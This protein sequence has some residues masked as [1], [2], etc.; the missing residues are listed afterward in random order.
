MPATL[1]ASVQD[2]II[3]RLRSQ[4]MDKRKDLWGPR[5]LKLPPFREINHSIP[6]IDENYR[7]FSRPGKCPEQ[8]RQVYME[9]I[10]TYE[11]A[12][13]WQRASVPAAMPM[14]P[15][16][17]KDNRI[18]T[19]VD[20][21]QRNDNTVK[22]V[23]PFPDQD[24]IRR[25]V[26]RAKY[27]SKVDQ[28][29]FFEQIRVIPDVVGKTAF[30]TPFGTFVSLVA[31]QGDCNVPSTAQQLMNFLFRKILGQYVHAY[32]DDIFVFSDTLEEHEEHLGTVFQILRD[33]ELYLSKDKIDLY[34]KS[35][36]C[37]G[38]VID[39]NGLHADEDK[40]S[41]IIAWKEMSTV[42]EVQRFLGLVQYLAQFF[43]NLSTMTG[44]ISKLTHKGQPFEWGPLQAD[45][46]DKLQRAAANAPILKPIDP[47]HNDDPI[48]VVTD[49]STSGVGGLYGQ[50]KTWQ[51]MRPAGFHSRKFNAA[52]MN[53]RTH[54]QELLA[55]L[56]ALMK[57]EDQLLGRPFTII[58][59]HRSLEYLQT[60]KTLSG[61]QIH[62]LE[63]L[64]RFTYK[65]QYVAGETNVVA[66]YLSRFWENPTVP[67]EPH[68]F[69]NADAR[70]SDEDEE[71]SMT[72]LYSAAIRRNAAPAADATPTSDIPSTRPTLPTAIKTAI[73]VD[74]AGNDLT[75]VVQGGYKTDL[76]FRQILAKPQDHTA[77]FKYSDGFIWRKVDDGSLTLCIPGALF[78]DGQGR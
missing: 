40:L 28:A 43:P 73:D 71:P 11:K 16:P 38:H 27:R 21:R 24:V 34:S 31:Q 62:W 54:E 36:V 61:R 10:N 25:D 20:A 37:L 76:L 6:L 35:L 30:S 44:P 41:K 5:K 60:Q 42:K 48:F 74:G 2:A 22:D 47:A 23:T 29:D 14:M 58:T 45:C 67:S 69:V 1:A 55:A 8:F 18:R 33:A 7:P 68:D 63:Y 26:A 52:Q 46:L 32:L 70:L 9:K 15:I 51:S 3:D 78:K 53:Y 56:E 64:S 49:A 75:P 77:F 4:W 50:G 19:V 59:D 39:D 65:I 57:W 12:G 17:K 13:L 72:T 66:D